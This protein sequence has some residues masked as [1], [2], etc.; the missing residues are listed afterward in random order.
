MTRKDTRGGIGVPVSLPLL[1]PL[2]SRSFENRD[3]KDYI[4]KTSDGSEV[5]L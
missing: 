2:G 4:K 3:C 1:P 5:T